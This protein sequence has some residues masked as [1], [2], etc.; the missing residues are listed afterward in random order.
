MAATSIRSTELIDEADIDL[1]LAEYEESDPI[2]LSERADRALR[3]EINGGDDRDGDR[4]G[5]RYTR[6]GDAVLKAKQ[7]VGVV[8]L[9]DGPTIEIRPK[10]AG[11]NLLYLL[12]YAHGVDTVTT[13]HP[14]RLREGTTFVDALAAIYESELSN[15]IDKGLSSGYRQRQSTERHL[16][17]QLDI[18][19]Q[20][21]RQGPKPTAF[22]C[23]YDELTQDTIVNQ[24]ILYATSLLI[25]LTRDESISEALFQH[26]QLLRRRVTLRPV[27]PVELDQVQLNRL[28]DY[29]A[30][31]LRLTALVLRN[32]N[33]SEFEIGSRASFGLLVNMNTVFER[34]VERA[35][36]TIT[37]ERQG[38]TSLPQDKSQNL[39]HGGKHA[40]TLKPDVTIQ[41]ADGRVRAI[42]DAKWKTDSPTNPDFY[43][44]AAY[45]LAH[46][47]SGFLIY[48][49]QD[50]MIA[51]QCQVADQQQL[52]LVELPTASQYDTFQEFKDALHGSLS[53]NIEAIT[54]RSGR[55]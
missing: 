46:E 48:P 10:A 39:I 55:V 24:A 50:G 17:G 11:T 41:D 25:G 4:I 37:A 15:V 22:E 44:M 40:I 47:S 53:Q 21:Q 35:C 8:S 38:W 33:I 26:C 3:S 13:E 52:S 18:Q 43:Q 49:E 1:V 12:R 29:Y 30:D 54:P 32:I 31:L 7:Y 9:P 23:T 2:P 36:N 27:S 16:R 42:L 45:Q 19:R 6:D 34:A 20:I 28:N 5:I 14:T 51:S